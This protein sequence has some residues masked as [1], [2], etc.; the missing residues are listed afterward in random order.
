[1]TKS[2][3]LLLTILLFS[4]NEKTVSIAQV[5]NTIVQDTITK[6]IS[7]VRKTSKEDDYHSIIRKLNEIEELEVVHEKTIAS[8]YGNKFNGRKTASG[9]TFNN[10][11]FTAA[12]KTLPFGTKVL[13]TNL[14]NGKS[15]V[16]EINDRGPFIK[17]R[18][19]DLSK[20]AFMELTNNKNK[21]L[22]NVKIEILPDDYNN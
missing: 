12:H 5:S 8:Y 10:T 21:G 1:M 7:E 15:V 9:K 4:C 13:V 14:K 18:K 20:S 16:V 2:K 11:K 22:L 3:I 17:G 6:E 19:I